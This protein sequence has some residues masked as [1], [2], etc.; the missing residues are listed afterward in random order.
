MDPS[1]LQ[2]YQFKNWLVVL[3]WRSFWF[4]HLPSHTHT[5]PV[6]HTRIYFSRFSFH[7][8]IRSFVRSFIH[9]YLSLFFTNKNDNEN[10][11]RR[12]INMEQKLHP[13]GKWEMKSDFHNY[14]KSC[15]QACS[16]AFTALHNAQSLL[17]TVNSK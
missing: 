11:A 17:F 13:N 6:V 7:F 9:L 3:S 2:K 14:K 10:A 4:F 5:Y 1:V 12:R 15:T 8:P 16:H